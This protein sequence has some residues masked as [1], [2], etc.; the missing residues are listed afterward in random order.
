MI[1]ITLAVWL[2][3]TYYAVRT[4]ALPFDV[5]KMENVPLLFISFITKTAN[6]LIAS[7]KQ[8]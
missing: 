1:S 4:T 5:R 2:S 7:Q 3:D 8:L 6:L